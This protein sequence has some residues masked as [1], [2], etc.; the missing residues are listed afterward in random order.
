MRTV[1]Q[2]L[3]YS[4]RELREHFPE[5]CRAISSRYKN[6]SKIRGEQKI[7]QMKDDVRRATLEIHSQGLYPSSNKVGSLLSEPGV[8]RA[9]VIAKFWH[10]MLQELGQAD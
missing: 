2:R 1:A 4:P 9:P 5:L 10:E 8:M 6:Y 7:Q 3:S